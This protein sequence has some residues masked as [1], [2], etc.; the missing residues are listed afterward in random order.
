M[1]PETNWDFKAIAGAG[2]VRSTARDL[3]KFAKANLADDGPLQ[4]AFRLVQRPNTATRTTGRPWASDGTS[5][6]TASLAGTTV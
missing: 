5:P 1:E 2:A 3:L 6:T 4:E